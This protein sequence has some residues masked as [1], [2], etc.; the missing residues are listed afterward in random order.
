MLVSPIKKQHSLFRVRTRG[1]S[2]RHS[3]VEDLTRRLSSYNVPVDYWRGL[4]LNERNGRHKKI[5]ETA[6]Q[7]RNFVSEPKS[8]NL[9]AMPPKQ[10]D[11]TRAAQRTRY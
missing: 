3:R 2:S 10:L 5:Q 9:H 7:F 6:V 11:A 1:D 4:N 8:F